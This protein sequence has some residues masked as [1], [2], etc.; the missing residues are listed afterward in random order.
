MF[1]LL[2]LRSPAPV[3]CAKDGIALA[4]G[5]KKPEFKSVDSL[6]DD[7]VDIVS[8]NGVFLLNVGPKAD[9]TIPDE[10]KDILLGIGKWLDINGEAIYGT[11]AWHTYGEGPTKGQ[12]GHMAE[13]K[14]KFAAYSAKDIRF[15]TKDNILY[16]ICLDWPESEKELTISS[17][18][19]RT[20]LSSEGI[21]DIS[22]LG[23]EGKLKW[24]RDETSLKIQL[25]DQKPGEHAFVFK[26]TLRGDVISGVK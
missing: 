18:G 9:G 12:T 15:T 21:S 8:K 19:T 23:A 11:R 1:L 22:L 17:L 7:L 6:I 5:R 25:P 20:Y 14:S 16:A 2:S 10:A 13:K 3:F 26:I 4:L 24:A